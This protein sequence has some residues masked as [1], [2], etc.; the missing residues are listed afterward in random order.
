MLWRFRSRR[1]SSGYQAATLFTAEWPLSG[2]SPNAYYETMSGQSVAHLMMT[3]RRLFYSNTC[4]KVYSGSSAEAA[5]GIL[6]EKWPVLSADRPQLNS[7]SA[8]FRIN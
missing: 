3:F 6:N 7:H 8:V 4:R 1:K 5:S 2:A